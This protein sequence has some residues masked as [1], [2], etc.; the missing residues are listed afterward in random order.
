[1]SNYIKP[2][3]TI[4]SNASS[5]ATDPGPLSVALSLSATPDDSGR[6]TVDS[7]IAAKTHTFASATDH[8]TIID[9]STEDA[10]SE[11]AG[12]NGCF[13][14]CRNASASDL[15]VFIGIEPDNDAA[16]DLASNANVQRLFTLRKGEFAFFPFD[17]T[18]DLT[19]DGES[20]AVIEYFVFNRA[21][22]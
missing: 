20:G 13:V 6:L 16:A 8:F 7:L 12:V 5:A 4:T 22:S 17:Y 10:G 19:T 9:G 15:D 11:V 3:L 14:Y 21:N 2:T 18:M 1:M